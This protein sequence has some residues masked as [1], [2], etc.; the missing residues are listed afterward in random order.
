[1]IYEIPDDSGFLAIINNDKYNSYVAENC[2]FEHLITHF[3]NE[4]ERKSLLIWGTGKENTWKVRITR[5]VTGIKGFRDISGPISVTNNKLYL[6]N[7]ES[8]T[9]AA[10]FND[11]MLPEKHFKDLIIE[12]ENGY[13]EIH[14]VQM[15]DPDNYET[16][17]EY[18]FLIE[19]QSTD[20]I[21]NSWKEI[22]WFDNHP[23]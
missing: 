5:G 4:M 23:Y 16:Q 13:Y 3:Q 6:V 7:Y 10:Q 14:I 8:L 21:G 17:S 1:M 9:M 11:I 19:Y 12:L 20:I 18:D 15:H 22:P 2:S